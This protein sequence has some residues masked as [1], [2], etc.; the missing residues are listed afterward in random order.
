MTLGDRRGKPGSESVEPTGK[1]LLVCI[2]VTH[3]YF[4]DGIL[5]S[6]RGL[7]LGLWGDGSELALRNFAI[8]A[9]LELALE[10]V[11]AYSR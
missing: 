5:E 8:S 2:L 1:G 10:L 7:L 11:L 9:A 6:P 4:L 3:S